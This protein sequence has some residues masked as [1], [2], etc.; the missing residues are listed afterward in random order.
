MAGDSSK[1]LLKL[2]TTQLNRPNMPPPPVAATP[3][4]ETPRPI[5]KISSSRQSS[6][7]GDLPTPS[8]EKKTIR[9]RVNSSQPSTPAT[10]APPVKITKT[11]RSSKPT[12]KIL[13]ARKQNHDSDDD[14]EEDNAPMAGRRISK[15]QIRT[16]T[17]T[18]NPS[19]KAYAVQTPTGR[20]LLKPKGKAVEHKPGEAWDSEASD[21]E[22]D[23]VREGAVILRTLPG[24]STEYLNKAIEEGKI[25]L[26]KKSGG[27][28]LSVDWLDA[29][30][31]RAMVTIDGQQ[32]AA[33]LVDLPTIVEAMKTWDKKNFMKNMDITQMLL[34]FAKVKGEQE[35]KTVPLPSM[36]Q[37][38]DHKWPHGLTPPMHDAVNR[39]FRKQPSEKQLV[40]TAAQ[41]KKLL[42]EDAECI[43]PP[44]YEYLQDEVDSD[45]SGDEDAEGEEVDDYF[46]GADYGDEAT[47]EDAEM[48][49]ADLE[50]E[51]EAELAGEMD[52]EMADA[53]AE[54]ATPATQLEAQTPMTLEATTPAA[55]V[56]EGSDADGED[57]EEVSDEDDDD[58]DDDDD[59]DEEEAAK[60][61]ELRDMKN[62]M[63]GLQK[64]V[65]DLETQLQSQTNPLMRRRI[66]TNIENL[67]KE[68]SLRK[69]QL[70]ITDDE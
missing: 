48:D 70:N 15:I 4:A 31:R 24:P 61:A 32:F 44:K 38:M 10:A 42:A 59:M 69:A 46:E 64:K 40:S 9:I 52:V 6:F 28:E 50:A 11:G 8:G 13:A 36:V 65:L 41:V 27:A 12:E 23:P 66:L 34:C 26:D 7:S 53:D 49:H 51:L 21:R 14:D 55:I 33:V 30:D 16:P 2:E 39:R 67:K 3:S 20:L 56:A 37:Q 45:D 57:E 5:L 47:Q 22:D 1:P 19:K 63:V 29:K 25:G 17:T 58:E 35:A 43:G 60:Q 54:G 68:I 18:T 62:E